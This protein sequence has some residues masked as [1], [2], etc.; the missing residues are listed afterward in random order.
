MVCD[1]G[2]NLVRL[3]LQMVINEDD[4]VNEIEGRNLFFYVFEPFIKH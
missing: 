4:D 1:E 3:F 2:S